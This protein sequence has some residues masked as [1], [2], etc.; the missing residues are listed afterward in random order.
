MIE[1]QCG[2]MVKANRLKK[3]PAFYI[4]TVLALIITANL[5]KGKR[6]VNEISLPGL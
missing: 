4:T 5:R 6:S 1:N 2:S 3:M